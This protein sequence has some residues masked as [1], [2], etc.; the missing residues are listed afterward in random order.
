MII[1]VTNGLVELKYV[2]LVQQIVK[3]V[4]LLHVLHVTQDILYQDPTECSV[5]NVHLQ[6]VRHVTI[7]TKKFVMYVMTVLVQLMEQHVKLVQQN[8]KNV[9][10]KTQLAKHYVQN[11]MQII[12][13]M[14]RRMNVI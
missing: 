4:A 11:V 14:L 2:I 9:I 6:I 8:V 7:I 13:T 10:I 12:L 1:K 5:Q 3:H